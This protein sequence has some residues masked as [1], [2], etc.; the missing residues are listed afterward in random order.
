[1]K[2]NDRDNNDHERD[3]QERQRLRDQYA[4]IAALAGGLAHEIRNPL[5]TIRM[6]LEL[7]AEDVNDLGSESPH[8][9]RLLTKVGSVQNECERLE[10]ILNDFLQFASA[11]ELFLKPGNLNEVVEEFIDFFKA[12]AKDA[13]VDISWHPGTD[14]PHVKLDEKL[15]RQ[16]LQNLAQNAQQSMADGGVLEI[17]TSVRDGLVLLELIDSGCGMNQRTLSR[18]FQAFYSNKAGGSGLGLPTV[19]KIVEA[20][21]GEIACDSEVGQ[22]TRF[23]ISLPPV[24]E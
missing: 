15:F 18:M 17:Q 24:T 2:S 3:D 14:L 19:R 20:H 22:G 1:M 4:E 12:Q 8:A 21:R 13:G 6:N 11:G 5:S 10:A 7:M 23:T 16:V 9:R